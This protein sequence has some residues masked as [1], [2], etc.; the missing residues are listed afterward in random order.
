[1]WM[2]PEDKE[3]E[4]DDFQFQNLSFRKQFNLRGTKET[5]IIKGSNMIVLLF[6]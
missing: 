4:S 2:S 6:F 5:V 3:K 1:M